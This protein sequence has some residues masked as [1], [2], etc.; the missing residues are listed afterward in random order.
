MGADKP[1]FVIVD[2]HPIHKSK[3]IKEYVASQED[4]LKLFYLPSY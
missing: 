1:V 3:L 2:G 4:K